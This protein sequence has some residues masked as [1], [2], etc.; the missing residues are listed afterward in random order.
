MPEIGIWVSSAG[1]F[2]ITTLV[3]RKKMMNKAI[4]GNT[5]HFHNE[6]DLGGSEGLEG[7]YVGNINHALDAELTFFAQELTSAWRCSTR[8]LFSRYVPAA[9]QHVRSEVKSDAHHVVRSRLIA[10][11]RH[12]FAPDLFRELCFF[13]WL[14]AFRCDQDCSSLTCNKTV[15]ETCKAQLQC[16]LKVLLARTAA[17]LEP[18]TGVEC[19]AGRMCVRTMLFPTMLYG[20]TATGSHLWDIMLR[21][22][23]RMMLCSMKVCSFFTGVDAESPFKGAFPAAHEVFVL[24]SSRRERHLI[25]D[26]KVGNSTS[27]ACPHDPPSTGPEEVRSY[28]RRP[29]QPSSTS[30]ARRVCV[31]NS[32]FHRLSFLRVHLHARPEVHNGP[33]LLLWSREE[34]GAVLPWHSSF[35][36]CV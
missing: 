27:L 10:V 34:E 9:R 14:I 5:G 36:E 28:G 12:L 22:F 6:F 19:S 4:V 23:L 31:Q 7:M 1:N 30:L 18:T 3:H 24:A 20:V 25:H 15:Q 26:E 33:W 13:C 29:D 35:S 16:S 17:F 32:L 8:E 2:N 21:R 11:G